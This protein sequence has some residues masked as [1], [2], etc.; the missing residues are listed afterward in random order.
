MG[1][2]AVGIQIKAR[3]LERN[4]AHDRVSGLDRWRSRGWSNPP[5]PVLSLCA[6]LEQRACTQPMQA[7]AGSAALSSK[8]S[9]QGHPQ[10]GRQ[11]PLM[12]AAPEPVAA[13]P[14]PAAY[15]ALWSVLTAHCN[16]PANLRPMHQFRP[17][18]I[19]QHRQTMHRAFASISWWIQAPCES[20]QPCA[21]P[22]LAGIN[23]GSVQDWEQAGDRT[24]RRGHSISQAS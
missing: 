21:V 24:S 9:S 18:L 10:L 5:A 2:Q 6:W 8:V 23:T 16:A 7:V 19:S 11:A 3:I 17:A 12:A 20:R 13:Q 15:R 14:G 1:F 4:A 22:L